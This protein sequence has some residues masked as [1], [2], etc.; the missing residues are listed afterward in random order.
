MKIVLS[1]GGTGGH[2]YPA[3]TIANN[4]KALRPD[5][6]IVF[7]GTKEGLESQ[8][9]PRYGYQLQYITVAGFQRK[10]G[11]STITSAIKLLFG[12]KEAYRLIKKL[13]PD[14]V[15][16]TGG[17]VC[18]PI[19]IWA[20]FMG[21][22][23][24]IQEQNAMPG[25]TNKILAHFVKRIFL[26]YKEGEKYFSGK[27]PKIFTGNPVRKEI[28][29]DKKVAALKEFNLSPNKKTLLV[30][31]GSRGARSINLAMAY[32]EKK[33]AGRDD[34]QV[35]HAT[36]EEAYEKYIAQLDKK[37]LEADNIK[38]LPYIHEMP[39]ALAAAD[40]AVARAGAI[41]LAELMVKGIPSILIPY[42][43]ATANHQEFNARALE[44]AGA[45]VVIL[46]KELTGDKLQEEIEKMLVQDDVLIDMKAAA[47]KASKPQ[48]AA[49]IAAQALKLVKEDRGTV[50]AGQY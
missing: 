48:A 21:I 15:I 12:M 46:D 29:V 49:D 22:P 17:Y 47:M 9:I 1:G 38:I 45:A 42:P 50:S 5:A 3:I 18:G 4:I 39:L 20:A 19:L 10:F 32:V 23:T 43:Y 13:K 7:V 33:F 24:C 44:A 37:I 30:F 28:I 26:G 8:I 35:L 14:L 16:G 41:G 34:I 2:I 36:G 40:M 6:E 11:F 27:A 31:G 25:V